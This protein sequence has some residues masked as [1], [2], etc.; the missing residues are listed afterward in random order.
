MKKFWNE[1]VLNYIVALTTT[2]LIILTAYFA[3]SRIQ[4][5]K[6]VV[7]LVVTTTMPFII[8][9]VIAFLLAPFMYK[10]EGLLSAKT[11]LKSKLKRVLS[12]VASLVL[13]FFIIFIFFAIITPELVD[14]IVLLSNSIDGYLASL[15][16]ILDS[17]AFEFRSNRELMNWIITNIESAVQAGIAYVTE[18][19][20]TFITN[21]LSASIQVVKFAFNFLIGIIVATYYLLDYENLHKKT[22]MI[23]YAVCPKGMADELQRISTLSSRIFNQF[24][25]GKAIDSLIIGIICLVGCMIMKLP[26]YGLIAFVVGVTNM[27]P[28]FGP[29]IGAIPCMFLLL[30]VDPMKMLMFTLFIFFLQQLDGNVI[31]PAILGDALGLPS[32]LIMFAVIIGG[33]L[34]G[35]LGMFIGVPVFALIYTLFKEFVGKSLDKKKIVI[36]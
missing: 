23:V 25:V 26:Y 14:S 10:V 28:F 35:V 4:V 2:G 9:F 24:I 36:E 22:K 20:P 3:V 13:F 32:L 27:I 5:L 11:K 31:G 16:K 17:I 12:V 1:K 15:E 7:D 6:T 30:L 33:G 18:Y 19:I 34:F 21:A 8:G 29:F